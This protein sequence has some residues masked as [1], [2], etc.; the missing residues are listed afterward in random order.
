MLAILSP[1]KTL[2]ETSPYPSLHV[3]QPRLLKEAIT[4]NQLLRRYSEN[5]LAELMDISPKLAAL[6]HKRNSAF[7]ATQ[8]KKNARPALYLFKG[9]V[10]DGLD[11]LSLSAKQIDYTNTHI[12]IVSGLYGILRPLDLIQPYRLEMGTKLAS[13]KGKDLYAFW[14]NTLSEMLNTDAKAMGAD[15]LLNLA[16]IE[17]ADALNRKTLKLKEIKVEFKQKRGNKLQNIALL[18]KRARGAMARHLAETNAS[19]LADVRAF[20]TDGYRFDKT[21]S[22]AENLVFV[23]TS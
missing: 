23:R 17:Y 3:T 8:S 10:Y 1:S 4:L 9:D 16:S 6:N 12:R 7:S 5:D 14:G 19:S 21:L 15:I 20:C 22:S 2:D 13:D 18:A 11:A